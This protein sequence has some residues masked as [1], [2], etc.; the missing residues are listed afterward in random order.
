[1]GFI[2]LISVLASCGGGS[3]ASVAATQGPDPANAAGAAGTAPAPSPGTQAA[4]VPWGTERASAR[5]FISGHSLT[6][7]PLGEH[8][9]AIAGSL[10]GSSAARYNQQIV[11]GSPIRVRTDQP[12]GWAGYRLGKNRD[13]SNM[14]VIG[15][16]R[17]PATLGPGERYDT[18]V[19][20]ERHDLLGSLEWENTVRYLRHFHERL[21]AGNPQGRTYFYETWFDISNRAD[22]RAWIAHE[23]AASQAWQCVAARV[24]HSLAAEGRPDR[25]TSLPAGAALVDL[26]EKATQGTVAGVTGASVNDTVNRLLS[27]NVHLTPMGVYYMALVTYSAVYQRSP[28]GAWVPAGIGSTA[29]RSL[30]EHAW[31]F[32]SNFYANV[33][34]PNLDSC[35]TDVAQSFCQAYWGYRGQP[36]NAAGCTRTFSAADARRNPLFY[37][38]A[39]DTTY[40]FPAP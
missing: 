1:L 14:N 21:L 38:A 25:I 37:D 32:V 23:R 2:A 9:V 8:V 15:E 29:G 28:V 35:R 13:G 33:R 6:D 36:G 10:G 3:D 5:L 24:N 40:W 17:S 16:L 31:A 18:L 4:A 11:I 19:I 27:D 22:P 34:A 7:N 39:T 12:A 20:A 26:V 30:Q